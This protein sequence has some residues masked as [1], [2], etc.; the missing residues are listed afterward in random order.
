MVLILALSAA[1]LFERFPSC[2]E[3]VLG[4]P[5]KIKNLF[6]KTAVIFWAMAV[7]EA[8]CVSSCCVL[9]FGA[10]FLVRRDKAGSLNEPPKEALTPLLGLC[11]VRSELSSRAPKGCRFR[12]FGSSSIVFAFVG[13]ILM[14]SFWIPSCMAKSVGLRSCW[15]SNFCELEASLFVTLMRLTFFGG[16]ACTLL[17]AAPNPEEAPVDARFLLEA[18]IVGRLEALS[19]APSGS[20]PFLAEDPAGARLELFRVDEARL[21]AEARCLEEALDGVASGRR[22]VP[23]LRFRLSPAPSIPIPFGVSPNGSGAISELL[24]ARIGG[25]VIRR[26]VTGGLHGL[27]PISEP[28]EFVAARPS[29]RKLN[30]VAFSAS[31]AEDCLFCDVMLLSENPRNRVFRGVDNGSEADPLDHIERNLDLVLSNC[32]A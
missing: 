3:S 7:Y 31:V 16:S 26:L 29:I 12:F 18:L 15:S 4:R 10:A 9:S 5:L 30:G 17:L 27:L 11:G 8:A 22:S 25:R 19:V 14:S 24:L 21:P 1:P 13:S 20:S 23:D 28:G 32:C 2:T 6:S